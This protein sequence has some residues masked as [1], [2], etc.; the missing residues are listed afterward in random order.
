MWVYQGLV[1]KILH[2][3]PLEMEISGSL[4]FGE[5]I[6]YWFIK[7]AGVSEILFGIVFMVFYRQR[8]VA[9]LNMLALAGLLFATGILTPHLLIEAFN[10]VTTNLPLLVLS[11]QVYRTACQDS[12]GNQK[13][14]LY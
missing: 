7:C 3:A 2:I 6:T 10:P 12:Q 5:D 11:L 14:S 9:L 8:H 4:G 13:L 1:P